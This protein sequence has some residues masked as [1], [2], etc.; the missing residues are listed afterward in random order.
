LLR[1]GSANPDLRNDLEIADLTEAWSGTE[2]GVA[3]GAIDS[4]GA[5]R[6]LAGGQSAAISS[7]AEAINRLVA[8]LKGSHV[9]VLSNGQR[10]ADLDISTASDSTRFGLLAV[11][12]SNDA[13]AFFDNLQ[14]RQL[15]Q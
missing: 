10:L 15:E 14:I 9:E 8:R 4:G 3:R 11:G 2:F 5:V 6:V 7:G 1:F 12:G 13:V